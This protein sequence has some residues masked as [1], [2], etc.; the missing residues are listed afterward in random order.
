[1]KINLR[2]AAVVQQQ[3]QE[4][5]KRIGSEKS[6]ITV[7]LYDTDISARIAAQA[8]K[9]KL[10][11]QRVSRL[12]DVNRFLRD[13]VARKNAEAGIVGYL[14]EDAMLSTF[15]TR[16]RGMTE[17]QTSISQTALEKEIASRIATITSERN[18]YG[19]NEH[20]IDVN[21]IDE[22]FVESA[23]QELEQV[24]RRR[25][26]IKDEMVSINVRTEIDVPEQ[27]ALVLTELGLD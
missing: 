10:N 12:L 11:N 9:Y 17:L 18:L 14:A 22:A 25:R 4:E 8:E 26:K 1:M 7:S 15:E 27:V 21:V 2:K 24:R 19:R 20:N 16:L 23:K 5:V 3:I 6:S 13:V